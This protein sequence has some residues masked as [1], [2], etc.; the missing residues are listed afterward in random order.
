MDMKGFWVG[1]MPVQDFMDDFLAETPEPRP[2]DIHFDRL[3][4]RVNETNLIAAIT[5]FCPDLHHEDM[6]ATP[7]RGESSGLYRKPD[8]GTFNRWDNPLNQTSFEVDATN[9]VTNGL[10]AGAT[11]MDTDIF[12]PGSTNNASTHDIPVPSESV[13]ISFPNPDTP[14]SHPPPPKRGRSAATEAESRRYREIFGKMQL[15]W[16]LKFK[17]GKRTEDLFTTPSDLPNRKDRDPR[18]L[19]NKAGGARG[20]FASYAM[21]LFENSSR[22]FAFSVVILQEEARLMR[23]DRGGVVFSEAFN[24]M[25]TGY[26]AEFLWRFNHMSPAQRGFDTTVSAP[27]PSEDK[28]ARDA[29]DDARQKERKIP[30][31]AKDEEFRRFEVWDHGTCHVVVAGRPESYPHSFPGRATFGY[32]GVDV[33][34][35]AKPEIVYMKD[36]WRISLDGMPVEGEVYE[37]LQKHGVPYLPDYRYGG[38]VPDG[39]GFQQTVTHNYV[40]A[41]WAYQA[42][43]CQPHTHHR[44]VLGKVGRALNTFTSTWEL[45]SVLWDVIVCHSK[46]YEDAG[47]LHRDISAGNILIDEEGR[48]ILIDWD[49]CRNRFLLE[50]FVLVL[51]H[52]ILKY[53]PAGYTND[54]NFPK[55]FMAVFDDHTVGKNGEVTGGSAR[56]A[57]LA[58]L[59]FSPSELELGPLPAPLVGLM[60]RL[61]NYFQSIYLEAAM[62]HKAAT[63]ATPLPVTQ[64]E[65][66]ASAGRRGKKRIAT[67]TKEQKDETV[68]ALR[69]F[70]ANLSAQAKMRA[71]QRDR[72]LVALQSSRSFEEA[73][74]L[75]V[76]QREVEWPQDDRAE[77][78]LPEHLLPKDAGTTSM[79]TNLQIISETRR[80][81]QADSGRPAKR[82]K[83]SHSSRATHS[84][85]STSLTL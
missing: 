47:I 49:L 19:E 17:D 38:D 85:P 65:T 10:M 43:G 64:N 57:M 40:S 28:A 25:D 15:L 14:P 77:D 8:V 6:H 55:A 63:E 23:W 78:Q 30:L 76:E 12:S 80:A 44:F 39:G 60:N 32:V 35:L 69:D 82:A 75:F 5:P 9:N 56:R 7:G 31:P 83:Y 18:H 71:E 54:T 66:L 3:A 22:V 41:D 67:G 48:G 79:A 53:R 29:F 37:H 58:C 74:K 84:S 50:S 61:R 46:A 81:S 13:P 52:H 68:D 1:P 26:L 4:G 20:Q 51:F 36:T 2:G 45:C 33:T 42:K 34:D 72:T 70:D 73:F 27:S 62:A 21:T 16:D 59:T 24:W 11:P